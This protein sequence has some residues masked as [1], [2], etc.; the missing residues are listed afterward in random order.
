MKLKYA[1]V[2]GGSGSLGAAIARRLARDGLHVLITYTGNREGAQRVREEIQVAGGI[3]WIERAD[4]AD[5]NGVKKLVSAAYR[6][7]GQVDVL[8]NNAGVF[9]DESFFEI[10]EEG[11]DRTIA[12]NLKAPFFLSQ[13]IARKMKDM[14]V[15]G[16]II[17]IS[18]GGT[19]HVEGLNVSYA[20]AKGGLNV[21]T[22]AMAAHLGTFGITVN[23]ILPG[24][25][26]T[27]L[28]AH[29]FRD[30]TMRET[31]LSATRLR[32]FGSADDIAA[33]AAYFA[34]EDAGWTTGTLLGVDG[35]FT[36][37]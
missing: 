4:L 24:P 22:K 33:A 12:I 25:V 36:C 20:A 5:M 6:I 2:T 23:A 32:K 13:M 11:F 18:S 3:A 8:V 7:M 26:E 29:Q 9:C 14:G 27:K 30:P 31:L 21:M 16:R 35:G 28:N 17:H 1:L 37:N 15:P 10:T 34:S 19:K